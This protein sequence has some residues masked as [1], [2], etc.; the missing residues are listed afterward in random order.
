MKPVVVPK[1]NNLRRLHI[2]VYA[3]KIIEIEITIASK[4]LSNFESTLLIKILSVFIIV[5]AEIKLD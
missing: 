3:L 5:V 2:I 4:T 1:F